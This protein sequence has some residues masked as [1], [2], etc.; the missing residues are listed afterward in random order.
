VSLLSEIQEA[1]VDSRASVSSVLLKCQLLAARLDYAPLREWVDKEL[2]GYGADDLPDYRQLRGVDVLGTLA[3]PFGSSVNNMPIPATIVDEDQ[4]HELFD[5]E[6]RGGISGFEHLAESSE[7]AFQEKWPAHWTQYY[8]Q[9]P[10]TSNGMHLIDAWKV[11]PKGAVVGMLSTVRSRVLALASDLERVNPKAGDSVGI[12]PVSTQS[13]QRITAN[14]YGGHSHFVAPAG[15][16][17]AGTGSV[18]ASSSGADITTGGEHLEDDS[19]STRL[20]AEERDRTWFA[21]HPWISGISLGIITG[22]IPA[23]YLAI[24]GAHFPGH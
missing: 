11:I 5:V 8:G 24:W 15:D 12:Q 22:A 16:L 14:I 2:N 21:R 9:K 20:S 19:V 6:F 4:W 7:G 1:A 13:L 18:V 23:M 10:I 3:G 17:A